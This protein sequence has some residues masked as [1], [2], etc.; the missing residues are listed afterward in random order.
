VVALHIESAAAAGDD[1]TSRRL[2]AWWT[3][4]RERPES[5]PAD[6]EPVQA[7][8]VRAVGRATLPGVGDVYLKQMGFPRPRD[9]LR[10]AFRALPAVHEARCLEV[11]GRAG[12]LAPRVVA[13]GGERRFG[14]PRASLLVT[15]ALPA[16]GRLVSPSAAADVAL[17][18]AD[19]G[20]E[21]PD[22]HL[23]NFLVLE[24]GTVAVLDL[25]SATLRGAPLTPRARLAVATKLASSFAA[26]ERYFGDVP[27][28]A[29]VVAAFVARGLVT[30]DEAMA[31]TRRIVHD[32]TKDFRR[33]VLRCLRSS[34][35]FA[36]ERSLGRVRYVRRRPQ[37]PSD[38][39]IA[40]RL[41][42]GR[43]LRRLWIGD[44]A[45][46]LVGGRA[47]FRSF[48]Q[49]W[50]WSGR[51]TSLVGS[52]ESVGDAELDVPAIVR[53][54]LRARRALRLPGRVPDS[55]G[56][57]GDRADRPIGWAPSER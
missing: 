36:V 47:A 38:A 45:F 37:E 24:D 43:W 40:L 23:E 39:S 3:A 8:L 57:R 21:H 52:I 11:L 44:R 7:R 1:A 5:L 2:H 46:E 14:I 54:R 56:S 55:L 26:R 27:P 13:V 41:E 19:A 20:V 28:V 17:R 16:T 35:E 18:L 15:A 6:I 34:T 30:S 4:C 32:L 22:L 25:Q 12:I 33:G 10:Y 29:D 48:E 49:R 42:G 51:R 50:T 31:L 53:D 9:R